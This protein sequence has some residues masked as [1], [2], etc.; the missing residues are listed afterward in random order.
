MSLHGTE[1]GRYTFLTGFAVILGVGVEMERVFKSIISICLW[2]AILKF[3]N[4][5][6]HF[7]IKKKL[8]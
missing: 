7:Q 2:K 3:A 6:G 8:F 1:S 5:K 4:F